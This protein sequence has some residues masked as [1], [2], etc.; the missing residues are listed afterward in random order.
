MRNVS[1]GSVYFIGNSDV[2][3][4]SLKDCGELYTTLKKVFM[5]QD[6]NI[7]FDLKFFK[8]G[9]VGTLTRVDGK[10]Y[11]MI[12]D[13]A[14]DKIT[15]LDYD[16]F[17]RPDESRV[18]LDILSVDAPKPDDDVN[19]FRRKNDSY[20]RYG[21]ELVLDLG[22]YGIDLVADEKDCYI[23]AQTFSDLLLS[24]QYVNI[25][26]NGEAFFVATYGGVSTDSDEDNKSSDSDENTP[27]MGKLFYSVKPKKLARTW[28]NLTTLNCVLPSIIS[29]A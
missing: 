13:C 20:E 12:V 1:T 28:E 9:E 7:S 29:T 17:V 21:D 16:A 2:P 25:F 24:T 4:F 10:P 15:F 11:T 27:S 18:L 3:Y 19:F 14:A 8:S 6:Q 22:K 26:Y 23:P 5:H